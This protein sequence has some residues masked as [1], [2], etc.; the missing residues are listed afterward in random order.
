MF[1]PM[2]SMLAIYGL[3]AAAIVRISSLLC[4]AR[5]RA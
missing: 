5:A 2:M 3:L 4:A 1:L